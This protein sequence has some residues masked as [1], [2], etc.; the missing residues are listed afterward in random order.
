MASH[1]WSWE[2]RNQLGKVRGATPTRRHKPLSQL[3]GS[4]SSDGHLRGLDLT[5]VRR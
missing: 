5:A 3:H 4:L 2:D 1:A